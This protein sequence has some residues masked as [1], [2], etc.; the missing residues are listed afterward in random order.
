[1]LNLNGRKTILQI[2]IQV[3]WNDLQNRFTTRKKET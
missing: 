2:V 3:K 1:M